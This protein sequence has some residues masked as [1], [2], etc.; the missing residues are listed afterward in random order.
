MTTLNLTHH[1]LIAMPTLHDPNFEGGLIY[2]CRHDETGALGIMVN[3]QLDISLQDLFAQMQLS[4]NRHDLIGQHIYFGGPVATERGF[5]LHEHSGEWQSTLEVAEHIGLTTS[6]DLLHA[7]SD[8]AGPKRFL[9]A[10][11]YSSWEEGQ[12]EKELGE[13]AWLSVAA[14]SHILF[15][16]MPENRLQAALTKL[17]VNWASLSDEV[18]HA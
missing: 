7:V 12:L 1:F 5:V 17:G 13:N 4:L 6:R 14:D 15:D 3:R 18:G 9:I 8:G 2:L 11:G 16:C 10:L